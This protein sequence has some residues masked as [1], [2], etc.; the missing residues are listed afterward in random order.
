MKFWQFL[1]LA[2][3]ILGGVYLVAIAL[4]TWIVRQFRKRPSD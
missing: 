2:L 4:G 1:A 3:L